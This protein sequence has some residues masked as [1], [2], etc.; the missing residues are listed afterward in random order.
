MSP[1]SKSPSHW[2]PSVPRIGR[3]CSQPL[4]ALRLTTSLL[5]VAF[6]IT[7]K[8]RA[9]SWASTA[10]APAPSCS[11]TTCTASASGRVTRTVMSP[12]QLTCSI[13]VEAQECARTPSLLVWTSPVE[14]LSDSTHVT[15]YYSLYKM[16]TFRYLGNY[17]GSYMIPFMSD[18]D[19]SGMKQGFDISYVLL[20]CWVP[21][22]PIKFLH[23]TTL[24]LTVHIG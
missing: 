20:P 17:T 14:C 2:E 4:T 9:P 7:D 19:N 21:H 3:S 12:S 6:S 8:M 18:S 10:L 1:Q 13:W 23:V 5:A 24:H 11:M 15:I 22:P 16:K